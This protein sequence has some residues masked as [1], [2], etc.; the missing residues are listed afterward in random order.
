MYSKKNSFLD[1]KVTSYILKCRNR[2]V[3][4]ERWNKCN[5]N[6]STV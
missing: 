6:N 5:H 2:I 3:G 4:N 1:F